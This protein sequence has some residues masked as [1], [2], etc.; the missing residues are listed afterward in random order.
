MIK[1]RA[2]WNDNIAPLYRWLLSLTRGETALLLSVLFLGAVGAYGTHEFFTLSRNTYVGWMAAIGIELLYMGAAGISATGIAQQR[3]A[4]LLMLAGSIAS[5][6]FNVLVGFQARLPMLFEEMPQMPTAAQWVV[7]GGISFVEGAIV[8]FATVL[9][10]YLLH[11]KI[12]HRSEQDTEY[13]KLGDTERSI[14]DFL[15]SEGRKT[16]AELEAF[17]GT[18]AS[19]PVMRT[20]FTNL[21]AKGFIKSV[22]DGTKWYIESV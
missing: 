10:S 14:L 5:A 18:P 2:F 13:Y 21:K 3:I 6:F 22:K 9:I 7:H 11:M 15:R 16:K 19:N 12:T 20:A 4:V 17:T 8:P 1:V